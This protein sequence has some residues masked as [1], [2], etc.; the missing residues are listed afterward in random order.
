MHTFLI[1]FL[2]AVILN[3]LSIYPPLLYLYMY[4]YMYVCMYIILYTYIYVYFYPQDYRSSSI[5]LRCY[6]LVIDF[7]SLLLFFVY[8]PFWLVY[9]QIYGADFYHPRL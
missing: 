4:V 7:L 6:L 8:M 3:L 9:M 2:I 1:V 5:L